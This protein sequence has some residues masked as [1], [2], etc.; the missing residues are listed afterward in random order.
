MLMVFEDSWAK[1]GW[2]MLEH[3]DEVRF[4]W[5]RH[6]EAQNRS[7]HVRHAETATPTADSRGELE[8]LAV[9]GRSHS[10]LLNGKVPGPHCL[11][12]W[13]MGPRAS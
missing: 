11:V 8:C 9:V 1:C 2:S 12:P 3:I 13:K 10:R 5:D 4:T 6:Y 7:F